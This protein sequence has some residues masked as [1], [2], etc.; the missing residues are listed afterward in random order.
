VFVENLVH[1]FRVGSRSHLF[2]G[3]LSYEELQPALKLGTQH[4]GGQTFFYSAREVLGI[5]GKP[6]L[7]TSV[8]IS[9]HPRD[10]GV[11]CFYS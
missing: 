4:D 2:V 7:V 9:V 11:F 1:I 6:L 8:L 5:H 3:T 10:L